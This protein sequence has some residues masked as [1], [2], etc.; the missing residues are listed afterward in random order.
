M[1]CYKNLQLKQLNLTI[2]CEKYGDFFFINRTN[3]K[4]TEEYEIR[5]LRN[6]TVN[7][8]LSTPLYQKITHI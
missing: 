5:I 3:F 1:K 4:C 2:M 7:L 8:K 6:K